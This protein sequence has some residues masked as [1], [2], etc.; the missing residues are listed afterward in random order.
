MLSSSSVIL[1]QLWCKWHGAMLQFMP[2][3]QTRSLFVYLSNESWRQVVHLRIQSLQRLGRSVVV[4]GDLNISPQPVD[5]CCSGSGGRLHVQL[6][7][8]LMCSIGQL[9]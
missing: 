6:G 2:E 8:P 1:L 5:S 4:V 3:L 7:N 9:A